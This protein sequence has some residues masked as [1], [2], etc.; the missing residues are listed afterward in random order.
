[1][2]PRLYDGAE[3]AFTSFGDPLPDFIKCEVTE[4]R[5]GEYTLEAEYPTTG[6]MAD[7]IA[8]DKILYVKPSENAAQG[9][10][11][12]IVSVTS[13]LDGRM[14]I[15]GQHISYRLNSVIIKPC[16]GDLSG[17]TAMWNAMTGGS[18]M[19]GVNPFTFSSDIVLSSNK[20]FQNDKCTPL[21]AMLGGE[22]T[23]MLN[24]YGGEFKWEGFEVKLLSSRG[25]NRGVTIAYG[26]N[27]TGLEYTVDL[28]EY[29]NGVVAYYI[30]DNTKVNSSIR[31]A[32]DGMSYVRVIAVD[33]S[34]D[35]QSAPSGSQLNTWGDNYVAKNYVPPRVT[36]NV[37]FVPLW[38]TAEY[39]N[40]YELEHVNLCDTVKISYPPLGTDLTAKVVKTVYDVLQERYTAIQV[41]TPS[42]GLA[43]TINGIIKE[44]R[45][46]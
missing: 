5:N 19:L 30:K 31:W 25:S 46:K 34:S 16:S 12:R 23:C 15:T 33:A 42:T 37:S 44:L 17:P 14:Q 24:L 22:D 1:M 40:Y 27:I 11:F 21:R 8:V 10:P 26:K 36:V 41:G 9:E 3:T 2:T 13:N 29:W 18:N 6:T 7:A 28:S 4:V 43:D 35:F 39:A 32:S 45:R 38:Q 20:H